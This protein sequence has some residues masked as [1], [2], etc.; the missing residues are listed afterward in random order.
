[1]WNLQRERDHQGGGREI[2]SLREERITLLFGR[3]CRRLDSVRSPDDIIVCLGTERPGMNSGLP[4][5]TNY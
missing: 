5:G 4:D 2:D 3:D 1:L